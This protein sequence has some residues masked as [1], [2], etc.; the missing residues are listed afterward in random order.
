MEGASA[1]IAVTELLD[2][3]G[4]L[5]LVPTAL[6]STW[7]AQG[8]DTVTVT[9]RLNAAKPA[10]PWLTVSEAARLHIDD[11]DGMNLHRAI[12]KIS[13]ACNAGRIASE[14]AAFK[15]RLEPNSLDAWRLAERE[16]DLA[17]ADRNGL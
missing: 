14:G 1:N 13:R 3:E 15:R 6:V 8:L 7:Q 16:K 4:R 2:A 10:R 9:I 17:R 5:F 12:V 11:V